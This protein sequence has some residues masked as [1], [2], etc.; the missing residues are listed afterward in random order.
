MGRD[1]SNYA[2]QAP[3]LPVSKNGKE[4][5]V[6]GHMW[7]SLVCCGATAVDYIALK[8]WLKAAECKVT[9]ADPQSDPG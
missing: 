5:K 6:A 2:V 9:N 7:I 3:H 8:R 1:L 4:R